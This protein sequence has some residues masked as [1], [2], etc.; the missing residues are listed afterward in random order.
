MNQ[1][2][3]DVKLTTKDLYAFSMRHTYV[4]PSGVF[5]LIISLGSWIVC[6]LRFSSLDNTARLALFI[7]GCLFTI[8]Q[9]VML[10]FK[11]GAQARRSKDINAS[12]HYCLTEEG[13]LISQGEQEAQVKWSDVRKSIVLA[14]SAYLYMSPVRAFIFPKEQCGEKYSEICQMIRR[15]MDRQG[16]EVQDVP[17][18][19]KGQDASRREMDQD[20]PGEEKE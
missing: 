6:A 11:S 12:I 5:S 1:I 7:I 3:F 8:V 15:Q 18:D 16:E 2:E 4:G 17:E 20:S 9:P 13:I 10:Y 14:K 19:E